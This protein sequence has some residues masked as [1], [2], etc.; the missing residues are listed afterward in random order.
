M[1]WAGSTEL[2]CGKPNVESKTKTL[3]ASHHA[4]HA[5]EKFKY[6]RHGN[7]LHTQFLPSCFLKS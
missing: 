4:K 3:A 6:L 2:K 1:T 5:R 7:A